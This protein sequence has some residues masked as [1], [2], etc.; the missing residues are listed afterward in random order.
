MITAV[1]A[2]QPTEDDYSILY[3][4]TVVA[5]LRKLQAV[6]ES[7]A[8]LRRKQA[9]KGFVY[10]RNLS[11]STSTLERLTRT[12]WTP[13]RRPVEIRKFD[14]LK[15]G[16]KAMAVSIA[17]KRGGSKIHELHFLIETLIQLANLQ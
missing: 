4:R 11:T 2:A 17:M 10:V 13:H 9:V 16:P 12:H 7:R 15:N 14:A 5:Y 6:S 8:T 1:R 3:Y